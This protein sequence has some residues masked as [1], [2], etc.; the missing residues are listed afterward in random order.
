MAEQYS[1]MQKLSLAGMVIGC[2]M[3]VAGAGAPYWIISDPQGFGM[4]DALSQL[5][6]GYMGLFMVCVET[7]GE[8]DCE[9]IK[10]DGGSG[11][12]HTARVGASVCVL[13]SIVAAGASC[14]LAC[15]NC[16]RRFFVLGIVSFL[17]AVS[18]AYCVIVFSNNTESFMGSIKGFQVTSYGWAYYLFI[19]GVGTLAVV[20]FT[21]CCSAPNNPLRGIVL[22]QPA[23]GGS[24]VVVATST[25][26][27]AG[28]HPYG[29]LQEQGGPVATTHSS[30][31]VATN[32]Y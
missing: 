2:L 22:R 17:A 13:L 28:H 1:S 10:N 20:S 8:T 12:F 7:L 5:V 3:V 23:M 18:G 32:G 6:K 24:Q 27:S 25:T 31:V 30:T 15:C 29:Y 9:A 11:W 21:A 19:G 16:C 4:M 14:C 26:H